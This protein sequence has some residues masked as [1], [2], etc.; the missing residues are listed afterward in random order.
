MAEIARADGAPPRVN[1]VLIARPGTSVLDAAHALETAEAA[2]PNHVVVAGVEIAY[3]PGWEHAL[4]WGIPLAIEVPH[5]APEQATALSTL[6]GAPVRAKL[7]TQST[8]TTPVPSDHEM[9]HFIAACHLHG[10]AFKLTGGLHRAVAHTAPST[11][12]SATPPS[13]GVEDQHGV[14]N[15]MLATHLIAAGG[16]LDDARRALATRR[17]HTLATAVSTLTENDIT[18]MRSS[19][20]SFG[21]CSV[22]DPLT[23]LQRLGVI[24]SRIEQ[25]HR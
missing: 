13:G 14:L 23:D 21:C 25:E 1:V 7:R 11:H 10:L 2:L 20:T 6:A 3:Q 9:A 22:L 5:T 24:P 12:G 18:V 17:G 4:A 15:V 19:F 16:R 8:A